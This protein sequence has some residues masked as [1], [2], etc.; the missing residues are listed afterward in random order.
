M[1]RPMRA[2]PEHDLIMDVIT[3][4][5][6][7]FVARD[8]KDWAACWVQDDRTREVCVSSSFGATV[9]EGWDQILRHMQTVFDTGSVCDIVDFQR[10]NLNITV[11]GTMAH[12]VFEGLSTQ[13]NMRVEH[14]L[15][16]RVLEKSDGVWRILYLSFVLRG[17]QLIDAQRLAV[18]ATGH[19]LCAPEE[20]R[21]LLKSHP[22][23]QISNGRLRARR[24]AWDV[25]LQRGLR[26]AAQQ[27]GYF[28]HYRYT[29]QYGQNFRLP[30][31][32][33][34]TDDGGV[35]V[36]ILFVRDDVTFVEV[37]NAADIEARLNV[38]KSIFRLSDGQMRLASRIVSGDGLTAAATALG[39][40]KNTARTHL[41]RIYVKTGT[42]SQTALVRTLLSTG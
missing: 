23:L 20:A 28:Q 13:S 38:A 37:Q 12:V 27:H 9:L 4:E 14:T 8:M 21:A 26:T 3:R 39:I 2:D 34:E 22:S 29:S 1:N 35:S 33:G 31:V 5:T 32:L 6:D 18:D 16:T 41:S 36:C 24:R 42:H 11:S 15:E 19:V 25:E 10:K 17:H 7:A 40:S 30:L